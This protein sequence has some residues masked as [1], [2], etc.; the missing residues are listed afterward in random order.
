MRFRHALFLLALA[1]LVVLVLEPILI[2]GVTPL[3]QRLSEADRSSF[4]E[5]VIPVS[6]SLLGFYIA[7][8]AILAQLDPTRKIVDELKR[9]ESFSLLIANMLFAILLLFALTFVGIAGSVVSDSQA[10]MRA[11]E[12]LLLATVL[13]LA[14][15]GAFFG[16]VTYKVAVD[17]GKKK[18]ET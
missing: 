8:V 6:A 7:A 5:L 11:F 17:K 14:L 3:L 13:E 10:L 9:G 16:V 1:A 15:S 2:G 12:W 4:Y 18:A